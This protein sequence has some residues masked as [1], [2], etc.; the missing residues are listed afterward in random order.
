MKELDQ[1]E[2]NKQEDS[3]S[4]QVQDLFR[5]IWPS[6]GNSKMAENQVSIDRNSVSRGLI[7]LGRFLGGDSDEQATEQLSRF[8]RWPQ[9][10]EN[11]QLQDTDKMAK[12]QFD[13]RSFLRGVGSDLRESVI[14][15]LSPDSEA[16]AE[17][18]SWPWGKR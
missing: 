6:F 9:M 13:F 8:L 12:A 10:N 3:S 7:N 16:N 18:F 15:N 17:R 11:A 1:L 14:R 4:Q 2:A 5:R